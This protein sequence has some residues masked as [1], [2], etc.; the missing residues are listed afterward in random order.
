MFLRP[1]AFHEALGA[2]PQ[3]RTWYDLKNYRRCLSN[4]AGSHI[5]SL[6]CTVEVM[7]HPNGT[8]LF[9]SCPIRTVAV[10]SRLFR[11]ARKRPNT[12]RTN[13]YRKLKI[14]PIRPVFGQSDM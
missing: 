1:C 14:F 4:F 2:V 9:I 12:N 10:T 7:A 8:V 5:D 3:L 13:P 11:T 6:F